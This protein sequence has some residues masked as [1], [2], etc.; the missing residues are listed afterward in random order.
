MI[1]TIRLNKKWS[2]KTNYFKKVVAKEP[3]LGSSESSTLNPGNVG[4]LGAE[5]SIQYNWPYDFCSLIELGKLKTSFK[6]K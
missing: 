2:K 1:I 4:P 3:S 6:I 5:G